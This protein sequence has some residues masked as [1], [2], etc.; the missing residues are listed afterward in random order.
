MLILLCLITIACQ[1]PQKAPTP[2]FPEEPTISLYVE[3]DNNVIKIPLEQYLEGVVAAEMDVNW[4]VEALAAQSIIARTFTLEKIIAGGVKNRGTDAST[5][6][7]EFQAYAPEKINENVKKAVQNTRGKVVKYQGK[8]IK[9][10]F[11]A[12]GGGQTAASAEEGLAYTQEPTPY[13]HSVGDPGF[14]IT[15]SENKSWQ[16]VFSLAEIKNAISQTSGQYPDTINT[17]EIVEKGPSGRTTKIKF[18]NIIVNAPAL[19]LALDKQ[20]MRSTF[21]TDLKIADGK[22]IMQGKGYGHG[23]GMSQW[24]ANALARDGKT[25][26]EIINYFFKDIEVVKE[27]E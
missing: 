22:I 24:G 10:W 21:L 5:S 9:A 12:D 26:E 4:P 27:Y 11:F 25:A 19:R 14:A 1:K 15:I 8:F 2:T 13:I 16:A 20:K 17:V 18:D 3:K 6:I 7:E 23:V